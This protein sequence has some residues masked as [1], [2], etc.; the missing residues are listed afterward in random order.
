MGKYF[1]P[2]N[3]YYIL[4]TE[5]LFINMSFWVQVCSDINKPNGQYAVPNQRAAIMAFVSTLPIRKVQLLSYFNMCYLLSMLYKI[6]TSCW[7]VS[8]IGKVMERLLK[9]ICSVNVC[10][11][12]LKQR[13]L[14]VALFSSISSG[15]F[16]C[17]TTYFKLVWV[18]IYTS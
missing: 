13:A 5:L 11:D 9:E 16:D 17:F 2:S 1:F 3:L 12:L 7:Q 6:W 10:E 14:I 8:G 15:V 18:G 4:T